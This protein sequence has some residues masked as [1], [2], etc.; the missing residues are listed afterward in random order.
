METSKQ[1]AARARNHQIRIL[2]SIW[3]QL[4]G[5]QQIRY[6]E[7]KIIKL[8]LNEALSRLDAAPLDV[9]RLR[10]Q[11]EIADCQIESGDEFE[12]ARYLADRNEAAPFLPE[13]K[14]YTR[15]FQL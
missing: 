4:Q 13:V 1:R 12:A 15:R 3:A 9:A 8:I 10:L 5:I 14:S 7:A 2:H 11:L 6:S